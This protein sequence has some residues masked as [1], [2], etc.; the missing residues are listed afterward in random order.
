MARS[1][2]MTA[3]AFAVVA[4]LVG[5]LGFSLLG[6]REGASSAVGAILGVIWL[7]P[8]GYILG[9]L[10]A[11][12][13]GALVGLVGVRASGAPFVLI[14]ALV[15]AAAAALVGVFGGEGP[16]TDDGVTNLALIGGAAGL[17]AA[18]A[19]LGF[20]SHKPSFNE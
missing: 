12:L 17:V 10:P 9:V 4:P 3:M 2:L 7:L 11:A 1:I 18:F 15:S 5:T 8:F 6:Y 19:A 16:V 20:S 14:G 13:T